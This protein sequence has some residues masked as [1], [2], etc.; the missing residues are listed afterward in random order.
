MIGLPLLFL[1]VF[2]MLYSNPSTS[3]WKISVINET[4]AQPGK[5]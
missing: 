4:K 3:S 2:G 5:K 1:G